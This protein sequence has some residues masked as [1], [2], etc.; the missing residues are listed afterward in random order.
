MISKAFIE[1]PILA[2]VLSLV[3]VIAGAVAFGTLPVAQYPEIAPPIVQVKTTYPGANAVVLAE[4]VASPIEQEVNGVENM[5]YMASR[6]ANDGTYTLDITFA[7]GTD[8]DIAQVLVQNRVNTAMP[9]LPEEVKREGVTVKKRSANILL[10][11]AMSSPDE[12]YDSLFIH[13]YITLRIK[14]ELLRQKGVGDLSVFGAEDYSMRVWLDPNRLKAL[15]LTTRDVVRA[16][17]E[18]NVQVAAGQIGQPPS[19]PGKNFQLSINTLWRLAEPEEFEDIIIK[20]AEGT[21][22]TRVK[23]VGRVELGAKNYNT[24]F[25]SN[26]KEAAGISVYPLPGANAL[27]TA[28]AIRSTMERLGQAFPEGLQ[29]DIPF[30]TTLFIEESIRQV[31]QTLI[32]AAIIVFIVIFIFLGDWRASIIPGIAIP[33]SLIGTAAAMAASW[34]TSRASAHSTTGDTTPSA[35]RPCRMRTLRAALPA[36]VYPGQQDRTLVY[37]PGSVR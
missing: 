21:R 26:G 14:D 1:R 13:N 9:K 7:V 19:P 5:L 34:R 33:V 15:N 20:T 28:Q 6:S 36:E 23:D 18:Q 27:E 16:I 37:V 31:Y 10:F 17:Q 4:T 22:V 30:D 12:R 29:W 2:T 24:F 32:E 25:A 11:I 3:I 8:V 35:C